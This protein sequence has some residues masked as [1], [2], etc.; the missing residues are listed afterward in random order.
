MYIVHILRDMHYTLNVRQNLTE[1]K[2]NQIIILF[3]EK[4]IE[5]VF[6]II[7]KNILNRVNRLS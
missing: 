5:N 7:R 4:R 3:K 2:T 6:N 1:Q